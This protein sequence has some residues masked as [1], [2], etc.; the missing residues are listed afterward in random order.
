MNRRKKM[1]RKTILLTS[2][3]TAFSCISSLASGVTHSVISEYD[4]AKQRI[5]T[6]VTVS[7]EYGAESAYYKTS[8]AITDETKETADKIKA[9]KQINLNN[10]GNLDYS[11]E[12]SAKTGDYSLTV[13]TEGE[14]EVYKESISLVNYKDDSVILNGLYNNTLNPAGLV[15]LLD[16]ENSELVLDRGIYRNL[17]SANKLL[18]ADDYID[19]I[20]LFTLEEYKGDFSDLSFE[21]GLRSKNEEIIKYIIEN[22][23]DKTPIKTSPYYQDYLVLS[24]KSDVYRILANVNLSNDAEVLSAFGEGVAIASLKNAENKSVITSILNKFGMFDTLDSR[25]VLYESAVTSH[26][27][28]NKERINYVSDVA[29]LVLE[30]ILAAEYLYNQNQSFGGGGGGG[31]GGSYSTSH[32][33]SKSETKNPE[34]DVDFEKPVTFSDVSEN[35]WAFNA[36]KYLA[37]RNVVSGKEADKFYPESSI[38]RAEYIKIIAVAFGYDFVTTEKFFDD[39]TENDWYYPY[40]SAAYKE[41]IISGDGSKFRPNDKITRQDAFV[42]LSRALKLESKSEA[43]F[44]DAESISQYAVSHINALYEKGIVKGYSD[45]SIL[46]LSN[47]SRA[48]SARLIYNVKTGMEE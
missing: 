29:P 38:T 24:D 25:Y 48:E 28:S 47:I 7:G 31:G 33:A 8:V 15:A 42:I 16:N 23:P 10:E 13:K 5:A 45:N 14:D 6:M 32:E 17:D 41:G 27:Y 26:I 37:E 1:K 3:L 20:G 43:E 9:L 46:P 12:V 44:K 39:V 4:S 40:V 30:G 22:F 36:V 34:P 19:K 21:Y 18:L 11:F 2:A 35:H